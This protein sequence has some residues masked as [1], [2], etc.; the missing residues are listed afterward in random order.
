MEKEN[1]CDGNQNSNEVNSNIN[2][3]NKNENEIIFPIITKKEYENNL[4]EIKNNIKKLQDNLPNIQKYSPTLEDNFAE[5][6][7]NL[8]NK[9][10][11]ENILIRKYNNE[12][13]LSMKFYLNINK[14]KELILLNNIL[15][16]FINK[17]FKSY[18]NMLTQKGLFEIKHPISNFIKKNPYIILDSQIY[19]K[20]K[21]KIDI[22]KFLDKIENKEIKEYIIKNKIPLKTIYI[23]NN[24]GEMKDLLNQNLNNIKT[25]I[26]N[27]LN[28]NDFLNLFN[29]NK[30]ENLFDNIILKKC[31]INEMR[32]SLLFPN[33][34]NLYCEKL[35]FSPFGFDK[36]SNI[37]IL[38]LINCNLID[39]T[40]SQILQSIIPIKDTL[41][42][43]SFSNNRITLFNV[44]QIF[45]NLEELDLSYNKISR[46]EVNSIINFPKLKILDL[47]S[48]NFASLTNEWAGL[49]KHL[50]K[51]KICLF[52]QNIFVMRP[53]FK[54]IYYNYFNNNLQLLN[55]P[56]KKLNFECFFDK[57]NYELLKQINFNLFQN[58]IISLNLNC[59]ELD[60]AKIFELLENNYCLF[61]LREL[62]LKTNN[63]S[64]KF[65]TEFNRKKMYNLF[66]HLKK[67]NLSN[68]NI[69]FDKIEEFNE[70]K[71]FLSKTQ[72]LQKLYLKNL[73]IE[74]NMTEYL[75]KE[76]KFFYDS[77]KS[78]KAKLL[79]IFPEEEIKNLILFLKDNSNVVIYL[80]TTLKKEYSSKLKKHF[81]WV[82]NN[83]FFDD[84]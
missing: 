51:G 7:T 18:E 73:P 69:K 48:N 76:L 29:N 45:S 72:S 63:I 57:N 82:Y 52:F 2:N 68:N 67:L 65:F 43:L 79:L 42:I 9:I 60:D 14:F 5:F 3:D 6:I 37:K 77:K 27:N 11:E 8:N 19:D 84:K 64:N 36:F 83:F 4:N 62:L 71:D 81:N 74:N 38:S 58:S 50:S 80:R 26:M 10:E 70:I 46:F 34:H 23:D 56:I 15:H 35:Q 1:K 47:T 54:I 32:F 22:G 24:A 66:P 61:N 75:K 30:S 59:C 28:E 41:Q 44:N 31:K 17:E 39:F 25:L 12:K 16:E 21:D 49:S 40:F 20:I 55:Y 78:K 53:E 33:I 13:V